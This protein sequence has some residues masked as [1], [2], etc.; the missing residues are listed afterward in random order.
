MKHRI[1]LNPH[2]NNL[3]GSRRFDLI[4]RAFEETGLAFATS[5]TEHEGHATQLAREA[6]ERGEIVVAAGGDGT[7]NEAVNGLMQVADGGATPTLG[8]IANG[9]GNDFAD[10][11]GL[12][13]DVPTAVAA[14]AAGKTRQVDV[15]HVEVGSGQSM[16]FPNNSALAMEPL[17]N[18]H[19]RRVKHLT[20]TPRYVVGVI[21]ALFQLKAWEMQIEWEGGSYSGKSLLLSVC[22]G[23]RTG[24]TFMM[25]PGAQ[26]DDGLFDV[27][28]ADDMP[29]SKVLRVLPRMLNGSHLAHPKVSHFQTS[30][31][32]IQCSPGSPVH[33]DGE[34]L[35]DSAENI[36]YTIHPG[37][38]TL[39]S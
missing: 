30:W 19:T 34:M 28:L 36:T 21:R 7:I 27:V 12:S 29:M 5:V 26:V 32:K 15:G 20:G 10:M 38:L 14:I 2:S 24:S 4:S 25:A 1:I 37:K 31:L 9:T 35:S 39:I 8:I 6:A 33:A 11:Q 13:R 23:P 16:F 18:M 22:N 3:R 17:A